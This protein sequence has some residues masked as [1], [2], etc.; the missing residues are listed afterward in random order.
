MVPHATGGAGV[1]RRRSSSVKPATNFK[2]PDFEQEHA[3]VED[4]AEDI[5]RGPSPKPLLN[6]LPPGL[7]SS[8][9]WPGAKREMGA[10]YLSTNGS[11]LGA[12]HGRQKSLSEAIQTVRSRGRAASITENAHEIAEALKAPISMSLV[13]SFQIYAAHKQNRN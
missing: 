8:E 6:G 1:E 9:R 12:R 4:H 10:R 3:I 2:F 13:V 7:H 11:V 5:S